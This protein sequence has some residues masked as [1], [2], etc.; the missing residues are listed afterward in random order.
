MTA[1][2][3]LALLTEPSPATEMETGKHLD[4]LA[5]QSSPLEEWPAPGSALD[6]NLRA[7]SVFSFLNSRQAEDCRAQLRR[8]LGEEMCSYLMVFLLKPTRNAS[9]LRSIIACAGRMASTAGSSMPAGR[10]LMKPAPSFVKAD[11]MF[12]GVIVLADDGELLHVEASAFEF[13]D[14]LFSLGVRIVDCDS[15]VLFG[16]F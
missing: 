11:R 4:L 9:R 14:H 1:A 12:F 15:G 5:A 8:L 16:W 13:L 3:V 2:E 6:D 10:D 7:C